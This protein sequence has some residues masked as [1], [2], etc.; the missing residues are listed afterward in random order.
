MDD[1]N[2]KSMGQPNEITR[3]KRGCGTIGLIIIVSACVLI[4]VSGYFIYDQFVKEPEGLEV[5]ANLPP[6]THDNETLS[7]TLSIKNVA[8]KPVTVTQIQLGKTL[9]KF[10]HYNSSSINLEGPE[11]YPDYMAYE[12]DLIPPE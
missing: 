4:S 7:I 6:L 11:D 2:S 5:S 1:T 10:L 3:K 12:S 9:L 8:D